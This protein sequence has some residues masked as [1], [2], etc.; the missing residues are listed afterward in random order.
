MRISTLLRALGFASAAIALGACQYSPGIA[1]RTISFNRAVAE[2]GNQLILLNAIRASKRNPTFYSRLAGDNTTSTVTPAIGSSIPFIGTRSV[3]I[4]PATTV[5]GA[6]TAVTTLGRAVSSV[7]PG[8]TIT[9]QNQLTLTNMDDQPS[10]T[11]MMT[12][13]PMQIYQFFQN[14]GFNSE[15]LLLMFMG[16]VTL[17]EPQLR[18]LP[19]AVAVHCASSYATSPSTACKYYFGEAPP[20][21]YA[22]GNDAD[23]H[24]KFR[25]A[26]LVHQFDGKPVPIISSSCY[27]RHGQNPSVSDEKH[28]EISSVDPSYELASYKSYLRQRKD[29][30]DLYVHY[31]ST[32]DAE[33]YP[34]P[35]PDPSYSF[36]NDPAYFRYAGT[37]PSR[38]DA[39]KFR[40][41]I[42]F[43]QVERALLALGL[44]PASSPKH[45]ALYQLPADMAKN[46]PRYFADLTQ[47]SLEVAVT[48]K[49]V[50]VCKKTDQILLQ[51]DKDN[52]IAYALQLKLPAD[53]RGPSSEAYAPPSPGITDVALAP[54]ASAEQDPL[55]GCKS[56]I[57]QLIA[58][59]DSLSLPAIGFSQRSL[60]A[61][62]YYIGQIIRRQVAL[63]VDTPV[64]FVA[65][66]DDDGNAREEE[67][68]R[69]RTGAPTDDAIVQVDSGGETYYVPSICEGDDCS[70]VE[71]PNHASPQILTMLN[72][73]WGLEKTATALPTVSNVTVV[74]PP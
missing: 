20:Y 72:Q 4:T 58:P 67:L 46:N 14:E 56:K 45:D 1:D 73:I 48:D 9:E 47:Q 2:S 10:I 17:S 57:A 44:H 38:P 39:G 74:T 66:A 29:A 63:K 3:Q 54:E 35:A 26:D 37:P 15:E 16:N 50:G 70:F 12:P 40:D 71:Y 42:C 62:V 28:G 64:Y 25:E 11:G 51:M 18:N 55:Q 53:S 31:K 24:K 13:V 65:G 59:K 33:K 5:G 34:A 6:A 52:Y 19:N 60:E 8:L 49:A 69:I 21:D 43:Q 22:R 68:F 32:P 7:T 30:Y 27:D 23:H 41:F 36:S 61:M